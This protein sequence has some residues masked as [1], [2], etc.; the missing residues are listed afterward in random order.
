ME[1]SCILH[2]RF[3]L[4]PMRLSCKRKKTSDENIKSI[5]EYGEKAH[6]NYCR[7]SNNF[8]ISSDTVIRKLAMTLSYLLHNRGT[9]SFQLYKAQTISKDTVQ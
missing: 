6:S 5:R 8:D 2:C 4:T 3:G 9:L 1:K 7:V